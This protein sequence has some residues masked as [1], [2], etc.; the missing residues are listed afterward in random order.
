MYDP[1][2]VL[3]AV[4]ELG[5]GACDLE[6]LATLSIPADDAVMTGCAE[7]LT[8]NLFEDMTLSDSWASEYVD[9]TELD[10]SDGFYKQIVV[11]VDDMPDVAGCYS[12][13]TDEITISPDYCSDLVTLAHELVHMWVHRLRGFSMGY[14]EMVL[15][16]LWDELKSRQPDVIKG[17]FGL[18]ECH[19]HSELENSGGEHGLLFLLKSYDIDMRMGWPLGRTFGYDGYASAQGDCGCDYA[20][21]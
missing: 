18:L 4:L 14:Y 19:R 3:S 20:D 13:E 9:M 2:F 12:T 10:D 7:I 5:E 1:R 21:R 15:V 8:L 16:H 11:R 6:T 17:A